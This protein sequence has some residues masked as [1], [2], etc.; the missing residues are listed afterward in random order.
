MP[1]I[2]RAIRIVRQAKG[3]RLNVLAEK[4]RMSVPFLSLVERGEREPSL[5]ALE[6]IADA[7]GIPPEALLLLSQ[8]GRGTL[9]TTDQ[10]ARDLAKA[11]QKLVDVERKLR[12]K[13]KE[14]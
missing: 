3:F 10:R 5:G 7:L 4:S 12:D 11:I 8:T 6:R 9:R 14:V 1:S 13:L 2:G